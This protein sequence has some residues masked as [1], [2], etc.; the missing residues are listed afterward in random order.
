MKF[1]VSTTVVLFCQDRGVNEAV[2]CLT[3]NLKQLFLNIAV[4]QCVNHKKQRQMERVCVSVCIYHVR[5]STSCVIQEIQKMASCSAVS[6]DT[7]LHHTHTKHF[8]HFVNSGDF[9]FKPKPTQKKKF[10]NRCI[11]KRSYAFVALF[12]KSF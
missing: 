1:E 8:N 11:F 5:R 4:E 3:L 9:I 10:D 7:P 12:L 6:S 2:F